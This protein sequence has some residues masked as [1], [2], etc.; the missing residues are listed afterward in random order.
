MIII[1][2]ITV[3]LRVSVHIHIA[4][5]KMKMLQM[6]IKAANTHKLSLQQ[7]CAYETRIETGFYEVTKEIVE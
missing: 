6:M 4:R 2:I 1:V 5:G 7:M 3:Y